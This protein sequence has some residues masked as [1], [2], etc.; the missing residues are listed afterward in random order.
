MVV[1]GLLG[2]IVVVLSVLLILGVVPVSGV[3]IGAMFIL[4]TL[5]VGLPYWPGRSP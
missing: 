1:V 4:L 3:L 2:A 5:G